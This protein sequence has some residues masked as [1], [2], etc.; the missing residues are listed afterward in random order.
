LGVEQTR[1][2]EAAA[3]RIRRADARDIGSRVAAFIKRKPRNEERWKSGRESFRVAC[4]VYFPEQFYLGWSDDH[5]R[6]ISKIE[7]AVLH[8][9]Q[10][11]MAM[12][13]GQGKTCLA[14]AACIWALLYGHRK[15][16]VLIGSSDT[17][18]KGCLSSIQ[19]EIE[20]NERLAQ[21]FPAAIRPIIELDGVPQRAGGQT[22][23]GKLTH[24][25]W[26]GDEVIFPTGPDGINGSECYGGIIRVAGITGGVRGQK[27]KR[28]DGS[29]A[30]PDLVVLDDPQT[31]GSAKS[32]SQNVERE[33]IV[34]GAVLGLAGPDKKI[35][36]VMPCTVIRTGDM[37]DQILDKEKHPEWNGERTKM[38]YVW[39][40]S[41]LWEEYAR[42]RADGLRENGKLDKCTAFYKSNREKMDAGSKVAWE[43]RHNPDELS[44]IQHAWNL[45]LTDER[46]FFSEYQNDPLPDDTPGDYDLDPDFIAS[47]CNGLKRGQI[48]GDTQAI[49]AFIDIQQTSLWWTI[50]GW[51][52]D[53]TGWVLDYGC[54]PD[55]GDRA[56]Y[57]KGDIKRTLDGLYPQSGLEGQ[58]YGGLDV[59]VKKLA[60]RRFMTVADKGLKIERILID[61]N[62]AKSTD[63]VYEY[64]LASNF[65]NL[66]LPSHG[67]HIGPKQKPMHKWDKKRGERA[68]EGWKISPPSRRVTRMVVMDVSFWKSHIAERLQTPMGD[69]GCL[70]LFGKDPKIHRCFADHATSERGTI[71]G[72]DSTRRVTKWTLLP[73]RDNEWWDG[74]V[75]CAVG[76][77]IQG[78]EIQAKALSKGERGGKALRPALKNRQKIRKSFRE[79]YEAQRRK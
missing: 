70:S 32:I 48:H 19:T 58:I 15:Y 52:S 36:A 38:V 77:S 12:P 62:W 74:L 6:V 75:G 67:R 28:P 31:D 37:V 27:H 10:F 8:G 23:D 3:I 65:S 5:L 76:A 13:R 63:V 9:G 25:G 64:C 60:G 47:K 68:G 66:L 29:V 46:A 26:T 51:S 17:A 54:F 55:Q 16:V 69:R 42:I 43:E 21:D 71:E 1:D 49:T 2:R 59:L 35:A 34:A 56:Y 24:I 41:V 73:G 22:W 72:D 78:V 40:K 39:P 11:A 44:A 33:R 30:R 14:E 20:I 79:Q 61:A 57:T 18:A 45:R 4:E 7:G 53:F 50:C